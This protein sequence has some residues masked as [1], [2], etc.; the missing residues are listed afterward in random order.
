LA[1]GVAAAAL[2]STGC[3][4]SVKTA[5]PGSGTSSQTPTDSAGVSQHAGARVS[6][7]WLVP[8]APPS[9]WPVARIATGAAM[10]YPPGWTPVHSDAG[11]ASAALLGHDGIVVG[12][13]NVTPRQGD[14][15]LT[16]WPTFRVSH[17]QD[18]G[19][20]E[21]H[22]EATAQGASFLTGH[23]SCVRDSYVTKTNAHYIEVACLVRGKRAP[24]VIVAAALKADWA[25]LAPQ[26]EQAVSGFTT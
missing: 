10:P 5:E 20:R 15:T 12:Y 18:E 25:K 1:V 26:L 6:F 7:A 4:S 3:G 13:L 8:H 19:D 22:S 24:T 23:G 11:A 2:I 14:E 9:S 17:N 21:D 16:N